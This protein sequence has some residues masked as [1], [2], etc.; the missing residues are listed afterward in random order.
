MGKIAKQLIEI[1]LRGDRL[2][3]FKER[4]I[5]LRKTF[6]GRRGWPIHGRAVCRINQRRL[7]WPLVD[8]IR[9]ESRCPSQRL[10]RAVAE[11]RILGM[12][13]LAQRHFFRFRQRELKRLD[14]GSRVR[15]VTKWLVP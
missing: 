7:K 2:S 4:L 15:S 3:D 5:S 12:L 14:A 13:A 8:R 9:S 1:S 10:V 6:A 11:G